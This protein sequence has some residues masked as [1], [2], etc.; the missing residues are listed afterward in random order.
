MS[1]NEVI[2]FSLG[3]LLFGLASV[4]YMIEYKEAS[5]ALACLS[6]GS[7]GS[8]LLIPLLTNE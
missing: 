2:M 8:I 4:F 3:F 7:F 1:R 6:V 5:L